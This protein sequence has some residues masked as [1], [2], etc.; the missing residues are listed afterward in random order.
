MAGERVFPQFP[1]RWTPDIRD[2]IK[3]QAARNRRS[4]NAEILAI[5]EDGLGRAPAPAQL[6][7][8]EGE[9]A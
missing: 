5:L 9:A 6:Q 3:A 4:M 1:I 8:G 7:L 2:A